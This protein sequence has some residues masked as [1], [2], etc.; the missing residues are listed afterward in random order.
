MVILWFI[1]VFISPLLLFFMCVHAPFLIINE[2]QKPLKALLITARFSWKNGKTFVMTTL[3]ISGVVLLVAVFGG[4]LL[5]P[6]FQVVLH[7]I[8]QTVLHMF[9]KALL[10][11]NLFLFCVAL[12]L[13]LCFTAFILIVAQRYHSF[14]RPYFR[15]TFEQTES[16]VDEMS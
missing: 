2:Q 4:L 16:K 15:S 13:S 7:Y 3:F 14:F 12:V 6:V 10:V 11:V 1:D 9:I 8:T 5:R